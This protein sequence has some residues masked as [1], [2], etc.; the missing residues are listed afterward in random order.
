MKIKFEADFTPDDDFE[1]GITHPFII[2]GEN[3]RNCQHN[4]MLE[5]T[6]LEKR[7]RGRFSNPQIVKILD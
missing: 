2:E 4:A 5:L 7:W 3:K 1:P 6:R